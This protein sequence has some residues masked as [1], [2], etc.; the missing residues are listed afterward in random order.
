[1]LKHRL[2]LVSA[3]RERSDGLRVSMVLRLF[4][5]SVL[6]GTIVS[7]HSFSKKGVLTIG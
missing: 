7:M 1:M 5:E 4:Y 2:G 6:A 3:E